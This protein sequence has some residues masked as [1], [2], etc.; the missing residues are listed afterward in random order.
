M[1]IK[2]FVILRIFLEW[3]TRFIQKG[4][5]NKTNTSSKLTRASRDQ[6][7]IDPLIRVYLKHNQHM[8]VF[9]NT[10]L[11]RTLTNNQV[12]IFLSRKLLFVLNIL[13][14]LNLVLKIN[15]KYHKHSKTILSVT[16]TYIT[17]LKGYIHYS[18]VPA[19]WWRELPF[20]NELQIYAVQLL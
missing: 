20:R 6:S 14:N 16:V 13:Y 3:D 7:P 5:E 15:S 17:M 11:K 8:P 19:Y 10:P 12:S 1:R 18:G 9:C 2:L 4:C